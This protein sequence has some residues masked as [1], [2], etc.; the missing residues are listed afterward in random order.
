MRRAIPAAGFLA[1][2]LAATAVSGRLWFWTVCSSSPMSFAETDLDRNGRVSWAEADYVCNF[3]QREVRSGGKACT[4]Y[5][6][7]KDG[8]PLKIVCP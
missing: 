3:G 6:A 1:A 2:A 7:L 8:L 4:E 5:Y